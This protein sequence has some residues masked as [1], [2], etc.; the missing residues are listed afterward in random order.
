M[1]LSCAELTGSLNRDA[2][3]VGDSGGPKELR[4]RWGLEFYKS[5][6][7][8]PGSCFST[9]WVSVSQSVRRAN[10]LGCSAH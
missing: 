8:V 2:V 4:I 1:S 5:H 3:L 10:F 6:C 9:E 7:Y